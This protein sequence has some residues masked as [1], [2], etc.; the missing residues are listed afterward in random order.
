MKGQ[1]DSMDSLIKAQPQEVKINPKA[2]QPNIGYTKPSSK[3]QTAVVPTGQAGMTLESSGSST[4]KT[5]EGMYKKLGKAAKQVDL[6]RM[7]TIKKQSGG[8][9]MQQDKTKMDMS[10]E[11]NG[12]VKWAASLPKRLQET[13]DYD[14][15]GYFDKYGPVSVTGDQHLTDEFK[16]PNHVTFSNESIYNSPD[17]QG[18]EWRQGT[19]KKW[20]FIASPWNIKNVGVDSLQTYFK[21]NEP[22]SKLTL[23]PA[24]HKEGGPINVIADGAFHSRKHALKDEPDLAD[25]NI[26]L[27]GIPVVSEH[28]GE[29][30]QHAEVEHNELILH[31]DVTKELEALF[32]EG[33]DEAAIKA[34]RLLSK[35]IVKNTK[36]SRSKIIKNA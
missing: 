34:G 33:T 8:P 11:N 14:L 27:K 32:K 19:D 35:E 30:V 25:A 31:Y 24:S 26:T 22:Q 13:N 12:Y 20:E 3:T 16:K 36:D 18:G 17:H 6:K 4:T 1:R 7:K 21:E 10:N 2:L 29:I 5:A 15:K 28:K 9:I 23:P